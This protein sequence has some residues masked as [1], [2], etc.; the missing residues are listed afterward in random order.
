MTTPK[1]YDYNFKGV[2]IDPYRILDIYEIHHPAL[3]HA[4]KK[5][6]RSGRNQKT[7]AEDVK[8]TIDALNRFIEMGEE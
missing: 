5:L 1:Y 2:K 8:E 3:Q 6:L 7:V 4:I